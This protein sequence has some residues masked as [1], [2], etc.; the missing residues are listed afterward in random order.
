MQNH[1]RCLVV[2]GT[3]VCLVIPGW[4]GEAHTAPPPR[5]AASQTQVTTTAD[6][7]LLPV[8]VTQQGSA[9]IYFEAT[10]GAIRSNLKV[11]YR[12]KSCIFT[13]EPITHKAPWIWPPFAHQAPLLNA[14][15]RTALPNPHDHPVW[16]FCMRLETYPE[17]SYRVASLAAVSKNW[18][19]RQG[20]AKTSF[21]NSLITT[22]ANSQETYGELRELFSALGYRITLQSAE[23]VLVDRVKM[24]PY[25]AELSARGIG[26]NTPVPFDAILWFRVELQAAAR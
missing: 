20:R 15:L 17:M 9:R 12:D 25:G 8:T 3:L 4:A 26:P 22:L 21:T 6:G 13:T 5:R 2:L 14:T 19:R 16:S 18:D 23:K 10:L 11:S 7:T 24:L 1:D